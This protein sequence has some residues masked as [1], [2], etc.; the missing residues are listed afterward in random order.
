[1]KHVLSALGQTIL[2]LLVGAAV[3][4]WHPLGLSHVLW[5]SATQRR[6][7]EADWLVAVVGVYLVIV[8][9]EALR[10]RLRG[11]LAPA[12]LALA[13][14]IALGLAMKFGFK[15]SPSA[16]SDQLSV[17]KVHV[18]HLQPLV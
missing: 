4:L 2:L 10:K 8:L 18:A 16:A 12:T 11:G 15:T 17:D 6:T 3:M 14:A 9:I 13:L 1:M 7:F 5:Q